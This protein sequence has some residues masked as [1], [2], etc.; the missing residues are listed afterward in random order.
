MIAADRNCYGCFW[1]RLGA[2]AVDCV[3]LLIPTLLV[4]FL[5]RQA[6]PASTDAA[7]IVVDL[8][9]IC[10]NF[11]VWWVYTAVSLSSA[12]QA[13]VGKK[14]CG[15]KVVGY[16]GSRISFG[17]ATGRY[18]AGFLSVLLVFIGFIMIAWT[19]R[20]QGLHD[21]IAETYVVREGKNAA[22]AIT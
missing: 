19:R 6:T 9:D 3:V 21:M 8:V 11:V 7:Q 1:L 15:L 18:F 5:Y 12:W 2:Y 20:R 4:S 13:T 16:D 14:V 10:M 22:E 17:R